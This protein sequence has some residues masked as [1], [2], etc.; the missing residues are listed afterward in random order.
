M[1]AVI[2]CCKSF[3][4]DEINRFVQP[5]LLLAMWCKHNNDCYPKR[6]SSILFSPTSLLRTPNPHILLFSY[7]RSKTSA[8]CLFISLALA[9]GGF[10]FKMD[11]KQCVLLL[12]IAFLLFYITIGQTGMDFATL[13]TTEPVYYR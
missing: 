8:V 2:L 6:K 3:I 12:N 10:S 9:W 13:V 11:Q 1:L 7:L 5:S 4:V